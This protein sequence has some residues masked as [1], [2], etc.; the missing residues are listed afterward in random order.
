MSEANRFA[1]NESAF[2]AALWAA[3]ERAGH[4]SRDLDVHALQARLSERTD[5]LF[6]AN[7]DLVVDAGAEFALRLSA[8]VLASR[9]LLVVLSGTT[10]AA[11]DILRTAMVEPRRAGVAAWLETRMGI[12][13]DRPTEAFDQAARNFKRGGEATFGASFVYEQEALD[14]RYNSVAIRRCL[15]NDFFRRNQATELT[16]LFC[17]LDSLWADELNSGPYNVRF[18]RPTLLSAGDDRCR[19]QFTRVEK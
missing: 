13:P 16:T 19:F 3:L 11:L 14:A 1:G 7:R 10:E 2:A 5:A 9:D 17:S 15:F 6:A 12:R 18:E 8:L 4:L